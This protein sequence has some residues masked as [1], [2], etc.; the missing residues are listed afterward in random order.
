M[1]ITPLGGANEVGASCILTEIEGRR[2]LVDVGIR[3]NV[4][5]DKQLPDLNRLDKLGMPD[6]FLLTHA[7]TDHTGA[8]PE[9][10]RRWPSVKG[11]CTPATKAITR[12]LLNDSKNRLEREKQEGKESL[13]THEEINA[14]L[15]Y[16][17]RMVEVP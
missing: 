7:H 6:A 13:F 17:E 3:M 15:Q 11:Y 14:A 10:V 1:N 9:L 8:L 16:L 12:V 5:Q 2:I 4:K